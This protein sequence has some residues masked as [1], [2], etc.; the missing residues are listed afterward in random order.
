MVIIIVGI[1]K[2]AKE[3]VMGLF[4]VEVLFKSWSFIASFH[5]LSFVNITKTALHETGLHETAELTWAHMVPVGS[6]I[7]WLKKV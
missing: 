4:L 7:F 6:H 3:K 2:W 1:N 5:S